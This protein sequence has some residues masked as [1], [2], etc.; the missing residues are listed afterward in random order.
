MA[1]SKL[2]EYLVRL[3][4]LY[5]SNK[6]GKSEK[7]DERSVMNDY[8]GIKFRNEEEFYKACVFLE[9]KAEKEEREERKAQLIDYEA[10]GDDVLIVRK[11]VAKLLREE[12]PSE[13]IIGADLKVLS[14]E[15][16]SEE[17]MA[18]FARNR[19]R[20]LYHTRRLAEED[21]PKSR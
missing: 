18:E 20:S 5:F 2:L 13:S 10:A 3:K 16:L 1:T 6:E 17:E 21:W 4:K 12:L 14:T 15:E 19:Y 7:S 8:V 11:N 9:D